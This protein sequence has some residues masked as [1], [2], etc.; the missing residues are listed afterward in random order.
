MYTFDKRD[1]EDARA[2]ARISTVHVDGIL[3]ECLMEK[4]FI[5]CPYGTIK[6]MTCIS[7]F[8]HHQFSELTNLDSADDSNTCWIERHTGVA[9]VVDRSSLSHFRLP[10][11]PS[12]RNSAHCL[13]FSPK[14]QL[15]IRPRFGAVL[16]VNETDAQLSSGTILSNR[17]L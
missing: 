5:P 10:P 12:P 6:V 1:A 8:R 4:L 11:R 2:G 15:E 17:R 16:S 13:D 9:S 7:R 14:L 3:F